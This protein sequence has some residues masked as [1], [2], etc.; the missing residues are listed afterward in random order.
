VS[1]LLS[2]PTRLFALAA[3]TCALALGAALHTQHVLDMQP[4]PWCILQRLIF[5]GIF[6]FAVM[7]MLWRSRAG[8]MTAAAGMDLLAA[9]GVAAALWQHF[10]S[11]NTVSCSQT[12]ADKIIGATGLDHLLPDVFSATA[13]C[14]EAATTLV[15]V[16]YE[17]WSLATFAMVGALAVLA[18][19]SQWRRPR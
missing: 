9:T 1:Y 7:G 18:L 3:G 6:C 15:G 13:S 10:V 17:F 4:C 14:A 11:A 16:P 8:V 2:N 19:L 12:L 5:V